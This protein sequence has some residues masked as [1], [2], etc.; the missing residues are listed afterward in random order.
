MNSAGLSMY[1]ASS[2]RRV[3]FSVNRLGPTP[4]SDGSR[5]A[6]GVRVVIAYLLNGAEF[7]LNIKPFSANPEIP[8]VLWNP[9]IHY[10]FHTCPPPAPKLSQLDPVLTSTSYFLKMHLNI[11][12]SSMPG[13]SKW[14]LYLRC[15]H[16][17]PV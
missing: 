3:S 15:P 6:R 2:A 10:R 4:C 14:S 8:R 13:S 5:A 17:N 7:F 9:K 11:I 16:P 12:L 1:A